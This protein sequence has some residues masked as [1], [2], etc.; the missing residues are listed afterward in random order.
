MH[1]DGT[2]SIAWP[3]SSLH[4]P[5]SAHWRKTRQFRKLAHA[6]QHSLLHQLLSSISTS[7]D[8]IDLITIGLQFPRVELQHRPALRKLGV[9]P[10]KT[11]TRLAIVDALRTARHPHSLLTTMLLL[12]LQLLLPNQN[13][14]HLVRANHW[15]HIPQLVLGHVPQLIRVHYGVVTQGRSV[16][17]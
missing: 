17:Q 1:R 12:Q 10:E 14:I 4:L 7:Q 9:E 3:H 11:R 16:V 8:P 13:P 6:R 15:Y 2:C 5:A